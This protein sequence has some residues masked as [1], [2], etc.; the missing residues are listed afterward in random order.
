M[1]GAL[2]PPAMDF[3]IEKKVKAWS[4]FLVSVRGNTPFSK[5]RLN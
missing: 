1:S 3:P 2:S 5:I 4:R